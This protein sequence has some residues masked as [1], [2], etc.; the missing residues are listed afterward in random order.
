MGT[1][2]GKYAKNVPKCML[3]F[4]G[5]TLL[6]RQVQTLRACG[7]SDIVVARGYA[8]EK[9]N[10][11]GV[12]YRYNAE[13]AETNMAATLMCAREDLLECR[14]YAL[15]CYGDIIYEKR[16]V[17]K[18]MGCKA[19][20]G[21]LVD[22]GWQEY[23]KA[24]MQNWEEDVE[25]LQIGREGNIFELGTPRCPLSQAHARYIGLLKFS[26][27]AIG[28]FVETFEENKRE[29]WESNAPWMKS[30]SFKKAYMTCM[31]QALI[32]KGARAQAV[33]VRH[34]WMEFDTNEDYEKA[35]KWLQDGTIKRFFSIGNA[36]EGKA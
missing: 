32:D 27:D 25:S 16:L 28:K 12:T 10:M 5:K 13:Y 17:E 24:R 22:E 3:E 31:L 8:A 36:G 26:R 2:L 7:I 19:Q 29:H 34:G 18:L 33:K 14:D 1:R 23:W 30:K 4:A 11:G 15:V 6:E 35:D 9:I 21:V 20:I